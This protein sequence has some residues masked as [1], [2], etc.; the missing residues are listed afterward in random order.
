MML[1]L[2]LGMTY[3]VRGALPMMVGE[4][5]GVGL[6]ACLSVL[7]VSAI[8]LAYPAAFFWFKLLGGCYLIY[9]GLQMLRSRGSLAVPEPGSAPA[10]SATALASQGFVTAVAN[11]KGWAFFMALLPPFI[12]STQPLAGQLV[13]LI[14]LIL[15]LEFVSLL[16]YAGGGRMMATFLSRS[17]NV[18]RVNRIAGTLMVGVGVWLWLD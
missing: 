6:V 4:L 17:G 7:G 10:M 3:G 14:A 5:T 8:L 11:P 12:D 13:V 9:L 16:L 18:K 15:T 2:S 1:S